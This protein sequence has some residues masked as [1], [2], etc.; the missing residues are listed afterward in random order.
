MR[1]RCRDTRQ[2]RFDGRPRGGLNDDRDRP[3]LIRAKDRSTGMAQCSQRRW[4]AVAK[5]VVSTDGHDGNARMDGR[6]ERGTRGI[7]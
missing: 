1:I 5:Q 6:D 2:H 3:A 4:C 7:R